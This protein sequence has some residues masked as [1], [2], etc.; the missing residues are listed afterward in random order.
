MIA[1]Q[2][3]NDEHFSPSP[4]PPET[5]CELRGDVGR[6]DRAGGERGEREQHGGV[7]GLSGVE[8]VLQLAVA[9]SGPRLV[10]ALAGSRLSSS[11]PGAVPLAPSRLTLTSAPHWLVLPSTR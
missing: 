10:Q 8:E 7:V 1:A 9:L 3:A 4:V 5:S 11:G 2:S 6:V